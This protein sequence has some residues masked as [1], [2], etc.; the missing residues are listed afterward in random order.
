M[1]LYQVDAFAD[2]PFTGNPAAV[3]RTTA[4]LTDRLMLD[5]AI[6][7][8][9]SETA[10]LVPR[11][12]GSHELRWFT[13]GGEVD[14]CGHA[15]LASAHVLATDYQLDDPYVFHT[16]SGILTVSRSTDNTYL[17]DLPADKPEAVTSRTA[18]EEALGIP[19]LSLYRG[20]DDYLAVLESAEAVTQ[21]TPDQRR[22]AALQQRGLIIT[23]RGTET[24]FVSR[25]FY[26]AYAIDEDPV[27]GSAH[28][29]LTPYWSMRLRKNVLSAYQ[30]SP[31]G[32][33]LQCI[34][35]GARV[36]IIGKAH[37]YLRGDITISMP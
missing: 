26:P 12:D 23:A 4:P 20:S 5:I 28:T 11:A 25:C 3:L 18:V 17:M 34:Y 33:Y 15:T 6:E 16:K 21:C 31:R 29:V 22:V 24:D 37:T 7:N 2:K 35:K 14:L 30:A 36:A 8:N 10:Y 9:L 13:P 19:V 27:T 32:G 1:R